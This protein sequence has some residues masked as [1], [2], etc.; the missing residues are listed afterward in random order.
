MNKHKYQLDKLA[1]RKFGFPIAT[2]AY[3][4]PDNIMASKVVVG[5][6]LSKNEDPTELR[7]WFSKDQDVRNDPA[8][9]HD[10]VDFIRSNNV[11]RVVMVDK[12][13]GCP[14]EEGI[15]Y[16]M[17]EACPQCPYWKGRDRWGD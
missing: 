13:I 3:Y 14:H 15:D 4:G 2:V 12:I 11:H 6:I 7:K 5:I 10:M 9:L 1:N 8:I 16:P 17:G